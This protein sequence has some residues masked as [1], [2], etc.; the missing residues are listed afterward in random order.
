VRDDREG[1][2]AGDFLG[3]RHGG[4]EQRRSGVAEKR[5]Q[6]IKRG[7]AR[8]ERLFLPDRRIELCESAWQGAGGC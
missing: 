3:G 5:S 2:A 1:A 6:P 4:G 7:R 8:G